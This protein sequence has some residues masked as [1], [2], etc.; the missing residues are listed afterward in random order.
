MQEKT[1]A[2]QVDRGNRGKTDKHG[3]LDMMREWRRE[4]LTRDPKL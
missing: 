2:E 4:R 3:E 1:Q